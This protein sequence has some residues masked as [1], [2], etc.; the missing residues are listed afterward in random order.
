MVKILVVGAGA[1]GSFY[2]AKLS[3]AG[4]L[5]SIWARS[6][7][8]II[9]NNGIKIISTSQDAFDKGFAGKEI[10][11]HPHKIIQNLADNQEVYDYILVATKVL[12]D[13]DISS[14]ISHIIQ[15]KTKIIL[16]QNGIHIEDKIASNFNK[17]E[18]ISIV[19]FI[20][21]SRLSAGVINHQDYGKIIIGSYQKNYIS[22]AV[23]EL[24]NLWSISGVEVVMTKNILLERW[25]KLVW[26]GAFNPLSVVLGGKNT[27]EI[28]NNK[29][30][31]DLVIKIMQEICILAKADKC[32]LPNDVIE[33]N[34]LATQKMKPY[35]TSMLLDF[36]ANRPME[37]EAILGNVVKF[38]QSKSISI[39][40]LSTVYAIISSYKKNY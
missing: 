20:A 8:E 31:Y 15:P 27:Q 32:E 12:P 30:S 10:I 23:I 22:E 6:D 39:P 28:I 26:N 29:L 18:V 9:K 13:L 37:V 33:K 25:K 11:F 16:M 5:V 40:Y 19:A 2:G 4:A 21:V 38:A 7:Y 14:L 36:E 34:I 3:E 17:H 35:K 1:I 24:S